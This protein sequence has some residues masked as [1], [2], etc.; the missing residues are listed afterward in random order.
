MPRKM[1]AVGPYDLSTIQLPFGSEFDAL[2]TGFARERAG[3]EG[4]NN[5][6]LIANQHLLR[7]TQNAYV[8]ADI[9]AHGGIARA[10]T[11]ENLYKEYKLDIDAAIPGTNL[12]KLAHDLKKSMKIP[13]NQSVSAGWAGQHSLN[14]R[15]GLYI[16]HVKSAKSALPAMSLRLPP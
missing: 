9:E 2:E 14:P 4:Y 13:R 5:A 11:K 8:V 10:L 6:T 3:R 7:D 1:N 12:D 16:T 15:P